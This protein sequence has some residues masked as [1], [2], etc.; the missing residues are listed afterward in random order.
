MSVRFAMSF[1]ILKLSFRVLGCFRFAVS[2][3]CHTLSASHST[4][5]VCME[6]CSCFDELPCRAIPLPSCFG[7]PEGWIFSVDKSKSM[8]KRD[9]ANHEAQHAKYEAHAEQLTAQ[10]KLI[11]LRSPPDLGWQCRECGEVFMVAGKAVNHT[12]SRKRAA[13]LALPS[14]APKKARGKAVPREK[15]QKLLPD[16]ASGPSNPKSHLAEIPDWPGFG[17][18]DS[19]AKFSA[20]YF[21]A[22]GLAFLNMS[23]ST[24]SIRVQDALPCDARIGDFFEWPGEKT[25]LVA[26]WLSARKVR[27]T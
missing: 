13:T 10:L 27:F 11:H 22:G 3:T 7:K 16:E 24:N 17:Y 15:D 1:Q 4:H 2:S 12:C 14:V 20:N 23:S 26:S 5:S 9:L 8:W 18:E 25:F 19:S 6:F 21:Q